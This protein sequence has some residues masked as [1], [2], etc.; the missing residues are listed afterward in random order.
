MFTCHTIAEKTQSDWIRIHV[1]EEWDKMC[2]GVDDPKPPTSEQAYAILETLR[3]QFLARFGVRLRRERV[4][5]VLGDMDRHSPWL[6]DIALARAYQWDWPV[7]DA[8]T[9][10][11]RRALYQRLVAEGWHADDERDMRRRAAWFAGSERQRHVVGGAVR[12]LRSA[13]KA[14][15]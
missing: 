3:P 5:F 12:S 14:A 11:E 2:E 4:E 9:L 10:D 1:M 15:A 6:D 8:L 7:I 13:M